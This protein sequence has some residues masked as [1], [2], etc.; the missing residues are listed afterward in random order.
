M[1]KLFTVSE[2][3]TLCLTTC[4]CLMTSRGNRWWRWWRWWCWRRVTSTQ[5]RQTMT[6]A[7]YSAY[8]NKIIVFQ[9][10]PRSN[11]SPIKQ[12]A[13]LVTWGRFT[14]TPS[15]GV[16]PCEYPDNLYLSRN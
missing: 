7:V 1:M 12:E 2:R 6:C 11:P 16:T 5:W 14:L 4:C 13:P 10:V 8:S 15:L 9:T 3:W